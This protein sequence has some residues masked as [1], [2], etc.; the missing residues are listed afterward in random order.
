MTKQLLITCFM[1][2]VFFVIFSGYNA[3][4]LRQ[5]Q[6][7]VTAYNKN[8]APVKKLNILWLVTEDIS[9]YLACYGDSTAST[10]N[11]DRLAK[12][13]IRFTNVF[14]VSGVCAP[15]RSALITGMYPTYLG[16][17][18]MRNTNA[19]PAISMPKYSVVLPP[20][21]K[22][23]TEWMRRG[24][25]YCTNHSKEDYQF[26]G[27]KA[28]WDE[29]SEHAHYK[30]RTGGK[31]FFAVFNFNVTHE[32]Q[33]WMKKNDPLLVDP[34]KVKLRPYYHESPVI[35]KD[36]A[37]MYSNI[38]EMDQQVGK[39]LKELE[40]QGLMD[41]TIIV[42]YSD[43][44][45]PL[46]RAKREVYDEGLRVPMLIRFPYKQNAGTV[47]NEL[48]SFVDF[49]PTALSLAGINIPGYMQG[50]AFLGSQKSAA[51]KYIYAARDRMD[52]N[53]D[54]VRAVGDG[55]FKY[56]KNFQPEK[57][58]IQHVTY[59]LDM[60][61]MKEL[62]RLN[63]EGKLN[64]VQK[65]WF[66]KTKPVEELYDTQH[67]PYE[68]HDISGDATYAGTLT[69]LRTALAKWMEMTKDKGFIPE[70]QLLE[71]MW[72]N[73]VQPT[74]SEPVFSAAKNNITISCTTA[75]NSISWQVTP[76]GEEPSPNKWQIY[77]G[78][79]ALTSGMQL[80][81]FAERIGFKASGVRKFSVE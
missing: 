2:A 23:F 6:P 24:G 60:D 62:L 75:G 19:F 33:V 7:V 81:A 48:I 68:L 41:S 50:R 14:D 43:N 40:E 54:M 64:D 57:P 15:S 56:L 65:L 46:P 17:D 26:E 58:Y 67:D 44:G 79:I 11:L 38:M 31:P 25:Y 28:G 35:R 76:K 22:M 12:E 63:E 32:S 55:R 13:G 1:L 73:L 16:T 51:P 69:E 66:R 78:A 18:N 53:Y 59:R 20:E 45:G 34:A 29:S 3:S 30:D 52:A 71:S 5:H 70:R 42:W 47:N 74:T 36:V 49:A 61:L 21:V 27:L 80:Y 37:R 4:K 77:N 8:N 10:P 9:P 39:M 72:P